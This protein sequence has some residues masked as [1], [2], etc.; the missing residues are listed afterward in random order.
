MYMRDRIRKFLLAIV[1]FVVALVVSYGIIMGA[2]EIGIRGFLTAV[3]W[4]I[5]IAL[6]WDCR[7]ILRDMNSR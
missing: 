3:A 4:L 6:L 2:W 1:A 5:V 7:K